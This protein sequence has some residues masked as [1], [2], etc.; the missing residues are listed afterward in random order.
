M[1]NIKLPT[2]MFLFISMVLMTACAQEEQGSL[3]GKTKN[4]EAM[5]EYRNYENAGD[6]KLTIRYTGGEAAF[7]GQVQYKLI[8]GQKVLSEEKTFLNGDG[9]IIMSSVST[10]P[11][12]LAKADQIT[13]EIFWN[14]QKDVILLR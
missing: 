6:E 1:A 10:K 5:V 12:P 14:D 4:W 9:E 11:S 13:L 7:V 2:W 8:S 3:S